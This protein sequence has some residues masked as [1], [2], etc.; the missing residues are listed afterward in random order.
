M[1]STTKAVTGS[2]VTGVRTNAD[3]G[4]IL[5]MEVTYDDESTETVELVVMQTLAS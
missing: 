1:A 4:R 3:F 5:V 2:V